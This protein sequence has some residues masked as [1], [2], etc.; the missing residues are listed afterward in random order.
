MKLL[1]RRAMES[2][3][4]QNPLWRGRDEARLAPGLGLARTSLTS[5][6]KENLALN[7]PQAPHAWP[8]EVRQ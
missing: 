3:L 4:C 6:R 7:I 1:E 5:R 2:W 8:G